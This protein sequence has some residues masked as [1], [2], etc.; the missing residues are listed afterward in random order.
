[1]KVSTRLSSV[2]GAALVALC[3]MGIIAVYA[4]R[5]IHHLGT[6]LQTTSIG[7]AKLGTD[8]AVGIERAVGEVNAAPSELDLAQL[9]VKQERFHAL[10][11]EARQ[12]L[13]VSLAGDITAAVKASGGEIIDAVA[14]FEAASKKVFD[15]T[16]A[17]AQPDAIAA[18]HDLVGPAQ[19]ALQAAL[20]HFDQVTDRD[21]KDKAA[22]IESA[23]VTITWVVTGLAVT[24]VLGLATLGYVTVSR[25]VVWPIVAMNRVMMRLSGGD[26]SV[27]VPYAERSDEVGDMAKAVRVFK[28]GMIETEHLRAAQEAERLEAEAVKRAALVSMADKIETSTGEA[29][30]QI[31]LSTASMTSTADEMNALAGR[32]GSSAQSAAEAASHA[33]SNAQMVAS[34]AEELA[35][36]I[37]EISGQ[38]ARSNQI[39]DQAVSAGSE[40]RNAIETLNEQVRQIGSVADMISE[41]ASKTNLLALNATIEAARAGDAGKGFAVVAS[42]VK[43]LATQTARSTEEI[44]RCINDVRS[45]TGA[46]VTAVARI[47]ATIGEISAIAGSIAAAVEEQGAA[48][49]EIARNVTET[50]SAAGRMTDLNADVANDARQAGEHAANVLKDVRA[51][52]GAVADLKRSVVRTVRTSATEVD[53]REAPRFD[54][55]LPCRVAVPGS[56]VVSGRVVDFSEG[57]AQVANGP[58]LSIGISG[59]LHIEGLGMPV[60]FTV[61]HAEV[62]A[63]HLAF[64]VDEPARVRIRSFGEQVTGR[65]AA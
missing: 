15:H 49:A 30:A 26:S 54:V 19:S 34:S 38:I 63:L 52:D 46:A 1:M 35:A 20:K 10:L 16:A 65:Q 8:I 58:S 53:R 7:L 23:I 31:G 61:R 43:Q 29:L 11:A 14:K 18:L 12:T 21:S 2:L 17:F 3:A 27:D 32:T 64:A 13:S 33:L 5:E 9:R 42:E 24:L 59:T 57:G 37:R 41:I 60:P 25:G 62:G 36:S 48:T 4:A 22:V 56:D 40:T 51:L 6:D 39:V 50:A 28:D 45:A 55:D 44:S 47:E